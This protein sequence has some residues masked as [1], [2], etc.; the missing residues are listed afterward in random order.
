MLNVTAM[1]LGKL[2]GPAAGGLIIAQWGVAAPFFINGIS[3]F[4][5]MAALF[6]IRRGLARGATVVIP[7]RAGIAEGLRFIFSQ[8]VMRGLLKLEIVYSIFDINPVMIA[9]IARE[10]LD[11]GPSGLG[12]LLAAPALGSILGVIW[13]VAAKPPVR[14]GRFSLCCTAIYAVMFAV[15]AAS[16]SY[17]SSL[18]A[19]IVAGILDVLITVTRNSILQL[20]S[21]EAMRGRVMANVGTITRGIGPLAETQSG[22]LSALLGPKIALAVAAVALG[23]AA[24][25]TAAVNPALW[26]FSFA[27]ATDEEAT[28]R[29]DEA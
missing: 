3:F 24:I 6:G 13:L 7:F 17:A 16:G 5:L 12:M 21:P 22:T 29:K 1:R 10:V 25:T 9:I 19:L 28:D 8:P 27:S 23:G 11:A 14:Q 20:A 18:A 15:F 4:A 2:F 26:R